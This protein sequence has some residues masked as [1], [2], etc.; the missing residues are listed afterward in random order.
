MSTKSRKRT[1]RLSRKKA[2]QWK[3]C[4]TKDSM[5]ASRRLY[6]EGKAK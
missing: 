6:G 2:I 5:S 3:S 4:T 1:K